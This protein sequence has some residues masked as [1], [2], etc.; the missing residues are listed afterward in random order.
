MKVIEDF[1]SRPHKVVTFV[2]ERGKEQEW[3]EQRMLKVLPG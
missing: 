2:V 3:R 1:E